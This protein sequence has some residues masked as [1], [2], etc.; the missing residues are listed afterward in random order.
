MAVTTVMTVRPAV[1][2]L[3][4][5]SRPLLDPS[6]GREVVLHRPYVN[7]MFRQCFNQLALKNN[8]LIVLLL[9]SFS[10]DCLTVD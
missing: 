9:C 1:R 2:L 5:F 4:R 6:N 3:Q 10:N 8:S 7:N